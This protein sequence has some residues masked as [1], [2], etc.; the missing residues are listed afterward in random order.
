MKKKALFLIYSINLFLFS[1]KIRTKDSLSTKKT[2][3]NNKTDNK[4]TAQKSPAKNTSPYTLIPQSLVLTIPKKPIAP[5]KK[6]YLLP[7]DINRFI[8]IQDN[9]CCQNCI[10]KKKICQCGPPANCILAI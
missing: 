8:N 10:F 6:E 9:S 4:P 1:T 2:S 3:Q 7:E 5:Q